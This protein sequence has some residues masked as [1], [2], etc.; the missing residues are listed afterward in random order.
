MILKFRVSLPNIKGFAR[1][2]ELP[3]TTSLY[4][5]H[6]I[7]RDDMEFAHDLLIQFKALGRTGDLVARYGLFDL[8]CGAVDGVTLADA[9][10][11]GVASFVYFYDVTNKKN[12]IVTYEGEVEQVEGKHYPALV[13]ILGP[14]PIEF[15]NGY[16]AFVD[17][18]ESQKPLSPSKLGWNAISDDDN[19]DIDDDEDDEE[20]D[21]SDVEEDEDG[22]EV[23][24][25]E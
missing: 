12:V 24:D 21:G 18:P 4:N 2:Y 3:A 7:M 13:E 14:N 15:E 19:L 8:G 17:L 22:G 10:K 9:L 11:K 1:V 6:K 16:V 23:Y 25:E 20:E 5:F